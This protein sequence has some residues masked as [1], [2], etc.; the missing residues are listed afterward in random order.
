MGGLDAKSL[1]ADEIAPDRLAERVVDDL[2]NLVVDHVL[3]DGVR[4]ETRRLVP[5]GK[6]PVDVLGQ[7]VRVERRLVEK[8]GR[9]LLDVPVGQRDRLSPVDRPQCILELLYVRAVPRVEAILVM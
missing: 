2:R 9:S 3:E 6:A 7:R 4:V 8:V 5:G 1:V